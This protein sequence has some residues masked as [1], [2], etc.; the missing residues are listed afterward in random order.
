M[1]CTMFQI[2]GRTRRP[3]VAPMPPDVLL[4]LGKL[5]LSP[6]EVQ[7]SLSQFFKSCRI[8]GSLRLRGVF[9]G[10]RVER[11]RGRERVFVRIIWSSRAHERRRRDGNQAA[12]P[13]HEGLQSGCGMVWYTSMMGQREES[14]A[15]AAGEARSSAAFRA[16][17]AML[18]CS[19]CLFR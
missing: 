9:K 16:G 3:V 6:L 10:I 13:T 5:L 18:A 14:V 4:L 8:L 17:G 7:L 15:E 2:R 12:R 19:G 11:V 1:Q